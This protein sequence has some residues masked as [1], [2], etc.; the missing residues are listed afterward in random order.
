M[1]SGSNIDNRAVNTHFIG[2]VAKKVSTL[3]F[4]EGY[5]LWGQLVP[6]YQN[7][8]AYKMAQTL[9]KSHILCVFVKLNYQRKFR[10]SNFRLY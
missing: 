10:S 7:D 9:A 2:S 4:M 6:F 5:R 8:I 3:H 1:V